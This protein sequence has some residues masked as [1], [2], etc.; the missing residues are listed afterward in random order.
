MLGYFRQIFR[1]SRYNPFLILKNIKYNYFS[2]NI[3]RLNNVHLYIYPNVIV[4]LSKTATITLNGNMFLGQPSI[5]NNKQVSKL[6]MRENSHIGVNKKCELSDGFDIQIQSNGCWI[7]D[8]FHSNIDLEVSC[9]FTI[10]I[11]GTV[12]AGRHVR[13]KDF[14]GHK[15]NLEGYPFKAPIIIED[16]VWLCTGSTIN[17]GVTIC[18][19]SVIADNSNV[20]SD[21]SCNTFNQGNPS[22]VIEDNIKFEI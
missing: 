13:I 9:G 10:T 2:K 1:I 20:I 4:D 21:V 12:T 3:V 7:M 15:V 17:P 22:K 19:G 18:S 14:N 5:K 8:N 6:I 16:H 11:Q